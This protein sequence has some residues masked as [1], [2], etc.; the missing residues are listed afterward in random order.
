MH[1]WCATNYILEFRWWGVP[2]G[3]SQRY[4]AQDVR[5]GVGRRTIVC[6][7]D[8]AFFCSLSAPASTVRRVFL[9]DMRSI[10]DWLGGSHGEHRSH[11]E[12]DLGWEMM[13]RE[14]ERLTDD[15]EATFLGGC[16]G[17]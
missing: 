14:R 17:V 5:A 7:R 9:G 10:V 1:F 11:A 3:Y 16:K 12:R 15:G 6:G 13:E 8:L 4:R 2:Q